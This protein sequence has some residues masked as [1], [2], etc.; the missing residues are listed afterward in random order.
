MERKPVD[1]SF[2]KAIGY[3]PK[4][5][6][7]E[8]EFSTSSIFRYPLTPDDYAAFANAPSIG[9]HFHANIKRLPTVEKI[10]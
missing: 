2:I 6:I 7:C 10:A 1:S 5:G 3:D 9:K 4:A 8:V